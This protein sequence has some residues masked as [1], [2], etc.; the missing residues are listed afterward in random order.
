[1]LPPEIPKLSTDPPVRGFPPALLMG[2]RVRSD[3]L[4]SKVSSVYNDPPIMSPNKT[5]NLG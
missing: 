4:D 3:L 5:G 1:M 2:E